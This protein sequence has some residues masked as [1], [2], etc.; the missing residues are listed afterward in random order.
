MDIYKVK[1]NPDPLQCGVPQGSIIGPIVLLYIN[2]IPN[3]TSLK[4]L[5]FADD[6]TCRYSSASISHLYNVM[7][8]ELEK[9]NQK[10]CSADHALVQD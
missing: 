6:T 5:C 1:L 8:D 9:L 2:D 10:K 4:V 7:N 3:Y